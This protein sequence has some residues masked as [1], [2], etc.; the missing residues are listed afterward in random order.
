MPKYEYRFTTR[1]GLVQLAS[2]LE[3]ADDAA[4]KVRA[5][6]VFATFLDF[7][8]LEVWRL[9]M[10]VETLRRRPIAGESSSLAIASGAGAQ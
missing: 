4:A 3:V 5:Q 1:T 8:M 10:M 7:P 2:T 9:D 6:T